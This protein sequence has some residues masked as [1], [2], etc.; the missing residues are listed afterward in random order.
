MR[1]IREEQLALV[2]ADT[3]GP[4]RSTA[5]SV[6]ELQGTTIK[7][8]KEALERF[9]NQTPGQKWHEVLPHLSEARE[10]RLLPAGVAS[11]T[12]LQL[13]DITSELR[14]AIGQLR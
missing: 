12:L 13:I 4:L 7:S 2:V 6:L 9:I 11:A 1:G 14:S 5:A 10:T 8:G 3:A